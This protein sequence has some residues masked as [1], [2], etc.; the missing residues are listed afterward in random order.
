MTL[1]A[2]FVFAAA[3]VLLACYAGHLITT[4]TAHVGGGEP[5]QWW[6]SPGSGRLLRGHDA[7]GYRA[8]SHADALVTPVFLARRGESRRGHYSVSDVGR[9]LASYA[10]SRVG[11]RPL[12]CRLGYCREALDF[13]DACCILG[14]PGNRRGAPVACSAR[15]Q[16]P[17]VDTVSLEVKQAAIASL[18]CTSQV[19]GCNSSCLQRYRPLP[20]SIFAT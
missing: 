5:L 15:P 13:R 12:F 20:T 10:A 14:H 7:L 6:G 11:I 1:V 3:E 19:V 16:N 18:D 2:G 4:P 17:V 9:F 8:L